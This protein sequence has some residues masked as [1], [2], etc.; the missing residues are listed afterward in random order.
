MTVSLASRR[1]NSASPDT[2]GRSIYGHIHLKP[3]GFCGDEPG[4]AAVSHVVFTERQTYQYAGCTALSHVKHEPGKTAE[5]GFFKAGGADDLRAAVQGSPARRAGAHA[6]DHGAHA[7]NRTGTEIK[8]FEIRNAGAGIRP[9]AGVRLR[10]ILLYADSQRANHINVFQH[11]DRIKRIAYIITENTRIRRFEK[12]LT[13]S[14]V[15]GMSPGGNVY[16]KNS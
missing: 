13:Q 8:I 5:S 11:I 16:G 10:H 1:S 7:G 9:Q 4:K 12:A 15:R 3:P 2:T 6:K 14:E